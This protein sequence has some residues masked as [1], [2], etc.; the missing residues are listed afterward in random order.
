[1]KHRLVLAAA[2]APLLALTLLPSIA[3]TADPEPLGR[4]EQSPIRIRHR[5]LDHTALPTLEFDYPDAAELTMTYIREDADD[6]DG[7]EV[8]GEEET[9]RGEVQPGTASLTVDDVEYDLLQVHW[10]TPGEHRLEGRTYPL[11]QHLVHRSAA[12]KLLVVG[13]WVRR[14]EAHHTLGT[15]YDNLAEEC[16]SSVAV[17]DVDLGELL[18]ARLTSYRY[19]GSLTTAPYTEGVSWVMLADPIAAS[20]DQIAVFRDAFPDGN[21][22]EVQRVGDRT[23]LTD[24]WAR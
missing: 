13:A 14:G 8:R 3:G 4:A 21:S 7:C 17:S 18:P 15:L 9:V 5:D 10:H 23:V 16:A 11:E 22:R 2:V 6:P 1:M 24:H 12:G 20:A 19:P